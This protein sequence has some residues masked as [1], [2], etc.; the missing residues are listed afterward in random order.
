MNLRSYFFDLPA[1]VIFLGETIIKPSM[2]KFRMFMAT[3]VICL[4]AAPF[5]N[6]CEDMT[7]DSLPTD[8]SGIAGTYRMTAF[9]IPMAVDYNTDG[10]SSTNL[11]NE[12]DCFVDNYIR[13][14]SD[15]TYARVDNYIDLSSGLPTCAEYSETGVWKRDGDLITTTSSDSNGYLPYDTEMVYD[16]ND[17]L[18]IS[19]TNVD[20][21]GAD[22]S[23]FPTTLQGDVSYVFAR[24]AE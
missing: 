16:G 12:S 2:K 10:T 8:N 18:T 6:S 11:M 3:A 20:Y 13:V 7:D 24:T 15:H 14:N 4:T 23:G 17:G 1:K 22:S 21:P 9:N 19:Y 5:L